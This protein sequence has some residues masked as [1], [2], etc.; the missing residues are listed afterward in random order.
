MEQTTLTQEELNFLTQA[1]Q[2]SENIVISFGQIAVERL[3]LANREQ[4]LDQLY[5]DNTKRFHTIVEKERE[6]SKQLFE[7]YGDAT[8]D[9]ETGLIKKNN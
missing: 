9:L 7:K 1:K 4:E 5:E 8:I 6:F 2:E 3:N